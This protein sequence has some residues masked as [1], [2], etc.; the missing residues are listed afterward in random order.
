M[1]RAAKGGSA[2]GDDLSLFRRAVEDDPELAPLA[3]R[4]RPRRLDEVEGQE[5]ILG[6]GKALRDAIESDRV[7]SLVLWGPPGSGKTTIARLVAEATRARFVPLSAV[8]AGV[9]EIRAIVKE[10]QDERSLRRRRTIVFVDEIHRFNRAQQDA[11]LPHVEG[12]VITLIGATTENPSFSVNAAL[13]SRLHVYRLNPLTREAV[14]RLLR[15]ARDDDRRGLRAAG[16]AVDDEV[17]EAIADRAFGDA[18]RGLNTI[19]VAAAFAR[20]QG[21]DRV[22]LETLRAAEEA[23]TYRHDKSLD[24]HYDLASAFIKSLRGSDP[25]AAVYYLARMLEAGEDPLFLLRR[26][27]IFASED[28]GLADPAAIQR[29]VALDQAFQRVGLPEGVLPLTQAA[30]YLALAPKSNSVLR[31]WHAARDEVQ[32]S[33]PLEVPLRL[34]NAPTGPM[35]DW[36]YGD[37]YRYPHEEP[38]GVA[39]GERYLPDGTGGVAVYEPGANPIEERALERL[40]RLGMWPPAHRGPGRP[41]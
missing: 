40:K 2:K 17:L 15:R 41:L 34:R 37:G 13:L 18:R 21:R 3:A 20:S 25:D 23:P 32:R 36:G 11:L 10:A 22:T 16:M 6:P 12:G 35:K 19:E 14:L 5:G 9:A 28:V 24:A 1:G 8:L 29:V 4:M 38:G 33:G 26:M 7:P 39:R 27:L 30:L 31:A